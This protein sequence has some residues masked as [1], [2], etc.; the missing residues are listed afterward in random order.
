[1]FKKRMV[2]YH[3][4][5]FLAKNIT[6]LNFNMKSSPNYLYENN[7]MNISSIEVSE[8]ESKSCFIFRGRRFLI[9]LAPFTLTNCYFINILQCDVFRSFLLILKSWRCFGMKIFKNSGAFDCIKFLT[10]KYS[11]CVSQSTLSNMR[12]ATSH[13]RRIYKYS[14]HWMLL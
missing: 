10:G 12:L 3:I 2:L 6:G 1:M 8:I 4:T 11:L 14:F 13:V 5:P 9:F 7:I